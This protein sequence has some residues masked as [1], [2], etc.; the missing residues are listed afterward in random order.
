MVNRAE[1]PLPPRDELKLGKVAVNPPRT[2]KDV[3]FAKSSRDS[4]A[5]LSSS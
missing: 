2:P 1:Y 5:N 3:F 4:L